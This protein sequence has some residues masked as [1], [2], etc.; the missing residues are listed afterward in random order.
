MEGKVRI[1]NAK[2]RNKVSL[3]RNTEWIILYFSEWNNIHECLY[4]GNQLEVVNQST[5]TS[6]RMWLGEEI[7]K[8]IFRG[9][10]NQLE[11]TMDKMITDKMTINLD[12]LLN[13]KW[14]LDEI[15][16]FDKVEKISWMK[17]GSVMVVWGRQW[18]C[19][20]DA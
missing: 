18:S 8:L 14:K 1:Q 17:F 10:W 4:I 9:Y 6:F 20:V 11:S 3:V 5:K 12:V 16:R 7:C 2:M 15:L 13:S 19:S